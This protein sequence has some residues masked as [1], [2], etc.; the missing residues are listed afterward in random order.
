MDYVVVSAFQPA[1]ACVNGWNSNKVL[2]LGLTNSA[3]DVIWAK[4]DL[5]SNTA[6]NHQD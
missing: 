2:S 4:S 3:Y 1:V 6:E 5:C